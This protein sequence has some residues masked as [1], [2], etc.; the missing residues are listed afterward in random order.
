MSGPADNTPVCE[1]CGRALHVL[2]CEPGKC[3]GDESLGT[4][5]VTPSGAR[6]ATA[7]ETTPTGPAAND[8]RLEHPLP[9]RWTNR[10][11][12]ALLDG[13]GRVLL[14]LAY[15]GPVS[16]YVRAVIERAGR[17]DVAL[18]EA[19]RM[20][21]ALAGHPIPFASELLAEIDAA[22]AGG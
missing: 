20:I 8:N 21:E 12:D 18:R 17:L 11:A 22:K 2:G 1:I 19:L 16:P 3:R 5:V 9:W 13:D 4:W 7:A 6:R 10:D 15:A 14:V